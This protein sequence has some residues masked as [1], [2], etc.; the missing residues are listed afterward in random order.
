VF[1]FGESVAGRGGVILSE[2]YL[3]QGNG[4][5]HAFHD[6]P[7]VLCFSSHQYPC[8]P[9]TG[10]FDETGSG[11]GFTVNAPFPRGFGDADYVR[12]FSGNS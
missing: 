5:R 9:G 3:H 10:N 4:T 12:F 2:W 6:D 1:Y 8:Y 7:Q 11:E